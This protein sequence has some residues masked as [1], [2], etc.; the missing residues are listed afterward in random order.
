[1]G[2]ST[3][4]REKNEKRNQTAKKQ[5]KNKKKT[6]K[7]PGLGSPSWLGP[8]SRF[9]AL[10]AELRGT[11][12]DWRVNFKITCNKYKT[13]CK[14]QVHKDS[15]EKVLILKGHFYK[16]VFLCLN[17]HGSVW[18]AFRLMS[19]ILLFRKRVNLTICGTKRP[20]MNEVKRRI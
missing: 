16:N 1:M 7:F 14:V 3:N 13:Y 20:L 10:P 9:N 17:N 18:A 19:S 6:G 15:G 8:L 5:K 2:K 12:H 11:C 4:H